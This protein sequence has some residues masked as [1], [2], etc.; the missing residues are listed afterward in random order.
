MQIVEAVQKKKFFQC[1]VISFKYL[2]EVKYDFTTITQ[3]CS[4]LLLIN[5]C[6][7]ICSILTSLTTRLFPT[8]WWDVAAKLSRQWFDLKICLLL[9][10]I[11]HSNADGFHQGKTENVEEGQ[12]MQFHHKKKAALQHLA[13]WK[14]K[15]YLSNWK[16]KL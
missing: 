15:I 12:N 14:W 2:L 9:A 1:I 3:E 8:K 7:I 11:W 4:T 5:S 10:K 6:T 16:R 13:T